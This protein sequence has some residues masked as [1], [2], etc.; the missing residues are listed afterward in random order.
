PSLGTTRD[1]LIDT[2][3]LKAVRNNSFLY[4]E[5]NNGEQELYD[6]RPGMVNYDPYQLQSRHA[7]PAYAGVRVQLAAKLN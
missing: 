5:Y 7:D 6:M 4:A 3:G 1:L 2:R